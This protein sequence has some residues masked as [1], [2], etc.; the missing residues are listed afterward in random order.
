MG[1]KIFSLFLAS[2]M[3][4]SLV[5]GMSGCKETPADYSGEDSGIIFTLDKTEFSANTLNL[6][7]TNQDIAIFD[8]FYKIDGEPTAFVGGDHS[9]RTLVTVRYNPSYNEFSVM[10]VDNSEGDKANTLIPVNGFV[11]SIPSNLLE[12]LRVRESQVVTVIGYDTKQCERL[13]LASFIP[14]ESTFAR[15]IYYV[16]PTEIP[17]EDLIYFVSEEFGKDIT[18]GNGVIAA[19]LEKKNSNSYTVSAFR[20]EGTLSAGTCAIIFNGKYNCEYAETVLK[21]GAYIMLSNLDSAN[22]VCHESAIKLN[23]T[24]YKIGAEHTNVSLEKDGVYLY[25]SAYSAGATPKSEKDFVAVAVKDGVVVYTGEKNERLVIPTNAGYVLVFCGDKIS[26]SESYTMGASV[27]ELLVFPE[28]TPEKF[29]KINNYC[30]SF[31]NVDVFEKD[32]PVLFTS[33]FGKTTGTSGNVAEIAIKDGKVVSV[34]TS[35]GNTEIPENGYVLS[36]SAKGENLAN[37][38]T[39]SVGD[40]AR[41][42]LDKCEYSLEHLDI[43]AFNGVR[44]TDFLVIYDKSNTRTGTNQYGFEI[45]VDANGVMISASNLGNMKVPEGG[46]VI[47]G[48]GKMHEAIAANY[49]YGGTVKLLKDENKVVFYSTPLSMQTDVTAALNNVKEKFSQA[50]HALYDIDYQFI[51]TKL[52]A[53]KT[54]I[55]SVE[56]SAKDGDPVNAINALYEITLRLADLEEAMITEKAVEERSVW[57]RSNVKSDEEV[58]AVIK[59]C[60]EY[61]INAIYVE[62]WYNG[63]TIG[64]T[65]NPLIQHYTEQHGDY[66]ALEGFVRIAHEHGIQIHAWVENFFVGTTSQMSGDPDHVGHHNEDWILL[67]KDG[68]G[69]YISPEYGNFVFLNP[70]NRECRDL[71]LAVYREL[72]E[73]Y[74]IDGLHLDY[75]RYPEHNGSADF[76][77]NEDTIKAFQKEYGYTTDPHNYK[78]GSK[79]YKDWISFRQD[80]ITTFVKEVNDLVK[81]VRPEVWITAACYPSLTDAPNQIYQYTSEWVKLGYIDQVFSMTYS[82]GTEYVKSNAESFIKACKDKALY[83]T[84]L[85]LFSGNSGE[86]LLSQIKGVREVGATGQAF[87]SLSSLLGF[88]EYENIII[89]HAYRNK[90]VSLFDVDGAVRA[91]ANDLLEKCDG[92]Y[93][94]RT[95][96]QE[97]VIAKVKKLLTEIKTE[98]EKQ[99]YNTVEEQKALLAYVTERTEAILAEAE[100][101]GSDLKN[102]LNREVGEMHYNLSVLYTRMEAKTAQ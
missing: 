21:E 57:Y 36:F 54:L 44:Y 2:L 37:C 18:L 39:V 30:Y 77:Y 102:A 41:V 38:K 94:Q 83:S 13:D 25:D 26:L 43:S 71:V 20:K 48:H 99:E 31:A 62:T 33:G 47:S 95:E 28:N 12:G 97:E 75:I 1:K 68:K 89:N 90:A 24:V 87:F 81:E 8:R 101:A 66:D 67:D 74:D 40:T 63:K 65:K 76:G 61:N 11:A 60:V 35:G 34:T 82:N 45:G 17:T 100:N 7:L 73:N 88:E 42:A 85:T 80:V 55:D 91:Y 70:Q 29:V 9:G 72:L 52:D 58:L 98:S 64:S 51:S 50:E 19:T 6:P 78:A 79:E 23:D 4:L 22:S 46:F 96:G 69:Y 53:C 3:L 16:N 93:S 49:I 27:E 59:K 92:V 84:G 32:V 56:S 14:S 15:R 86:E 5:A 10:S